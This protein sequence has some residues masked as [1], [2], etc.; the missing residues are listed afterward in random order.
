MDKHLSKAGVVCVE[1]EG[2]ILCGDVV[3]ECLE[4]LISQSLVI[5]LAPAG[6]N[7]DVWG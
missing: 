2:P 1:V 5:G 6:F 7:S 4:H 3:N